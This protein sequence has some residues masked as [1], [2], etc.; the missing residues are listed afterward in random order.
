MVVSL[1]TLESHLWESANILCGPV[2]AA[3]LEDLI[4]F[5]LSIK[6][7]YFNDTPEDDHD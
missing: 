3:D 5:L 4:S 7:K 6:A 2:D 1:N